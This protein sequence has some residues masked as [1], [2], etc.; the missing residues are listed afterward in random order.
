MK[1]IRVLL[2]LV[3]GLVV[4]AT[5]LIGVLLFVDPNTYRDQLEKGASLAFERPITIDGPI[6]LT[7][8][9]HPELEVEDLVLGNPDWATGPY[10]AKVDRLL[11]RVG[12]LSLLTGDLAAGLVT[13]DGVDVRLETDSGGNGNFTSQDPETPLVLP[14]IERFE[15]RQAAISYQPHGGVERRIAVQQAR[16]EQGSAGQRTLALTGTMDDLPVQMNAKIVR[17]VDR[18]VAQPLWSVEAKVQIADTELEV[19]GQTPHQE[20]LVT[21]EYRFHLKGDRLDRLNPLFDMKLPKNTPV[22]LKGAFRSSRNAD[23][24]KWEYSLDANGKETETRLKGASA[25]PYAL[26]GMEAEFDVKGKAFK[27]LA[28]LLG[29]DL[30]IK[31][32]YELSGKLAESGNK[33]KGKQRPWALDLVFAARGLTLKLEGKALHPGQPEDGHYRFELKGNPEQLGAITGIQIPSKDTYQLSGQLDASVGKDKGRWR[34]DLSLATE[35][36][37]LK[38]SGSTVRPFDTGGLD[39]GFSIEGERVESLLPLI[40]LTIPLQGKYRGSGKLVEHKDHYEFDQLKLQV[41][42]TGIEGRLAIY[43]KQPRSRIVAE[44]TANELHMQNLQLVS[45]DPEQGAESESGKRLIPDYTFPTALL[46]KADMN[47]SLRVDRV[48]TQLGELGQ[49]NLKTSLEDGVFRID[50]LEV[51]GWD[52]GEI[53][54]SLLFDATQEPPRI[55]QKWQAN[56]MNYGSLLA[57]AGV[58]D[59]LKGRV[60]LD[61]LLEGTGATRSAFLGSSKGHFILTGGAGQFASRKLELWGSDL[62]RTMFESDK[63]KED[64]THLNCVVARIA[65]EDGVAR[66]DDILVDTKKMTLAIVGTLNLAS[67]EIDL[68]LKPELKKTSLIS[69]ANPARVTGSLMSPRVSQARLP[70]ERLAVIGGGALA[71]LVNPAL[72]ILSFS[73]LGLHEENPCVSAVRDAETA[74]RGVELE[75]E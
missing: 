59:L 10:L 65:I 49:L 20:M 39:V 75:G 58:T 14:N 66:S 69:V 40:H 61:L 37:K 52:G 32:E 21:G 53:K 68:L 55:T 35:D 19:E 1:V 57:R 13:F 74:A 22:D 72:L 67:E 64:V 38:A 6:T 43:H 46:D 56:G 70:K 29:T 16:V 18:K 17:P 8:S 11:V 28:A 9:L 71:G 51:T 63:D 60:D 23:S 48:M 24:G 44:F 73:K 45:K 4:L 41:G 62:T 31:G 50:P 33:G 42:E 25:Q 34:L 54:A 2:V 5:G 7:R 47:V 12:L 3:V 15:L 27:S 26:P 30:D 36:V